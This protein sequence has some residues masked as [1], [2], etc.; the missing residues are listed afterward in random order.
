[1]KE[2]PRAELERMLGS[3]KSQILWN[4]EQGRPLPFVCRSAKTQAGP[5]MENIS[6]ADRSNPAGASC[7][8]E[9]VREE[10]G[11]C[12]RCS[13]SSLRKNLV[14]GEGNPKAELVFVGEAPG[15]DEDKEGRPFVGR[16]GQ[17]LTKII[18]AMGLTREDVRHCG[19]LMNWRVTFCLLVALLGSTWD[20]LL[21]QLPQRL[22]LKD[23]EA[24]AVQNHP[25]MHSAQFSASA[26]TQVT[27]ETQSA[28]FP[29]AFG[30]LTGAGAEQ[31]SRITAGGLN[32]P[33]IFNRYANGL[34][35]GQLVT[36]F[37]RTGN[38][39]GSA[40]LRAQ[41]AQEDVQATREE[42]LLQVDRAY[43]GVLRAQAI[44]KV[45]QQTVDERQTVSEQVTALEKS[46]LKS[47]LD[48]SF[49]NV[50]LAEAKLL[51]VQARNDVQAA[52]ATLSEALGD[53]EKRTFEL[54]DEPLPPSS[55]V[56][57][58]VLIDKAVHDRPELASQRFTEQASQRFAKAE[59]DLRLPTVSVLATV[60][61]TPVREDPLTGHY[62]AAGLN[63]NI[64]IFNGHLFSARRAEAD[65]RAQAEA[66]NLIN[67]EDR[68]VRDVR[69]AW[70]NAKSASERLGLTAQL[71]DQ[72]T[73]ALDLA[74]ARYKLGLGSIVELS[75]A[76]LNQTQAQIE[77]TSAKYDYQIQLAVLNYEVGAL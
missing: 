33:I 13:L 71:L 34:T 16:A 4:M 11:D 72:A 30:S 77:Q 6:Y 18:N 60:G 23:A 65:F 21:A 48:V 57:L 24:M 61:V 73:L 67:L 44:L 36:D 25:R 45:A 64:P 66:Q 59:W 29:F 35:M 19:G 17:L 43:Y 39:I 41:A 14:F 31:N 54:Q 55:L 22:T 68:V 56:D 76:Q 50:N 1:M 74:Q 70:L 37:G 28:Y 69:V 49:A 10:L 46:K 26:A 38:L 27:R 52:F 8:I 32:N 7:R 40:R 53:K 9:D 2:E 5:G 3:L 15:G 51:L 20:S 62:A 75:Q 58:P 42:I 12:R 47:A 63:I